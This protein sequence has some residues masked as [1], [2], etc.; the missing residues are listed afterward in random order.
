M[1]L[2]WLVYGISLLPTLK[3]VSFLSAFL[4]GIAAVIFWLTVVIDG[5]KVHRGFLWF[6]TIL[7]VFSVI[8]MVLLPS[9]KTAYTMVAAYATQKV[10]ERPEA[11]EAA[12]DVLTIINSKVK[13]YALE[14][15]KELE[16]ATNK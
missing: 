13:Q 3:F 14:S 5:T 12:K 4:G 16:K 9:E 11:Q 10:V 1:E 6:I 2:V 7:P 8:S 15:V